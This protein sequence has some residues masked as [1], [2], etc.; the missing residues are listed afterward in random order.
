MKSYY[1]LQNGRIDGPFDEAELEGLWKE[2]GLGVTDQLR[3][4]GS[5][6]WMPLKPVLDELA[7]RRVPKRKPGTWKLQL[8]PF[9]GLLVLA[10]LAGV[11]VV[12]VRYRD[13][14]G[15][16]GGANS[17]GAARAQVQTWMKRNAPDAELMNLSDEFGCDGNRCRLVVL[18]AKT[19]DGK[20]HSSSLIC[21]F[22]GGGVAWAMDTVEYQKALHDQH[23]EGE[24]RAIEEQ[25]FT[26]AAG[27]M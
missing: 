7:A 2:G 9:I 4:V 1:R 14:G 19:P 23:K 25:H 13:E 22:S 21:A 16:T 27:S 18:R 10:A 26:G 8:R 12:V 15:L 20:E 24:V 11:F 5:R 3:L 6:D 17:K